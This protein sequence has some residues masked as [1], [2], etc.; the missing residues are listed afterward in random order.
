MKFGRKTERRA[1][2][3]CK[4]HWWNGA[5]SKREFP[6]RYL[7]GVHMHATPFEWERC[8]A[9]RNYEQLR[10]FSVDYGIKCDKRLAIMQSVSMIVIIITYGFCCAC[11]WSQYLPIEYRLLFFAVCYLY[12]RFFS[13]RSLSWKRLH[14]AFAFRFRLHWIE[15]K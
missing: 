14:L 13:G 6:W 4:R 2:V 10:K 11:I 3:N 8:N 5:A 1:D 9:C 15:S 7:S 12:L